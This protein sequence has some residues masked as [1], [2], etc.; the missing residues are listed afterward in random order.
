VRGVGNNIGWSGVW[1]GTGRQQVGAGQMRQLRGAPT[2]GPEVLEP[3]DGAE[4]W[5]PMRGGVRA[6]KQHE[7][8]CEGASGGGDT[9]AAGVGSQLRAP[10]SVFRE[11]ELLRYGCHWLARVERPRCKGSPLPGGRGAQL[12]AVHRCAVAQQPAVQLSLFRRHRHR[13]RWLRHVVV[14][15]GSSPRPRPYFRTSYWLRR[16]PG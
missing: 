13:R 7:D 8:V 1:H 15:G 10:D 2:E 14:G 6:L 9:S 11:D 16:T 4:V 3:W 5:P 12:D